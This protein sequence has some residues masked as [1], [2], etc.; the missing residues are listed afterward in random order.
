MLSAVEFNNQRAI[1]AGKIN[2]ESS[3]RRLP[4]EAQASK[5]VR[6]QCGPQP[7]LGVRHRPA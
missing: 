7:Q 6:A 5:S 3:D 2:D 1:K 4:T